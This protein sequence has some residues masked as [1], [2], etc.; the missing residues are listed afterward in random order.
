MQRCRHCTCLSRGLCF[1]LTHLPAC[2]PALPVRR[3]RAHSGVPPRQPLPGIQRQL[4]RQPGGVGCRQRRRAAQVQQP[5]DSPRRPQ[6]ARP[7]A[8]C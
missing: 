5:S 2:L 4:R 1:L 6:L 8:L 7:A 3:P